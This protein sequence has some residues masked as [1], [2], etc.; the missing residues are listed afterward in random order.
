MLAKFWALKPWMQ[1]WVR[2]VAVMDCM[3]PESRCSS[4][5]KPHT[6]RPALCRCYEAASE[7]CNPQLCTSGQHGVHCA[8]I[9]LHSPLN[10]EQQA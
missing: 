6:C 5:A 9:R 7:L 2:M 3:K 1:L 8:Q 10:Q 4:F